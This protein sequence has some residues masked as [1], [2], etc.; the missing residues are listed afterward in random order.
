MKAFAQ[1][2]YG[3]AD[4]YE[5]VDVTKPVPSEDEVLVKVI[6]SAVN[7][8]ELSVLQAPWMMRFF[9]GLRRPRGKFHVMGCDMAGRVEAVGHN[10]ST[11]A[12]GDEVYGDLSGYRF[13]G[14]AEYVCVSARHLHHKPAVVSF[15][16][17]AAIPHTAELA[18]Q[19]M[20]SAS[21]L[22]AGHE[23]LVNGAAGGVGTLAIQLLKRHDLEVTGVDYAVKLGRLR[24]LG[25]DHVVAYPEEDFTRRGKRYDL[26]IDVKT[27]GPAYAYLRVLKPAGVYATVG[28]DKVFSFMLLA[29]LISPFTRKRLKMVMLKP[30][31][32]LAEISEL[33]GSEALKPV[34]DQIFAFSDLR[35]ALTRFRDAQ[36]VGKIVIRM[37]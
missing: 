4:V 11:F 26:I 24:E 36:R 32:N 20:Q 27:S 12:P 17:A 10:V 25:Y 6:A 21:E 13:G 22:R 35:Q 34:I 18:L 14:F 31:K 7:D 3:S 19:A 5:L 9:M 37:P 1:N 28:G 16:Q 30:N 2:G 8:W 33:F 15:E 23:V 29:P